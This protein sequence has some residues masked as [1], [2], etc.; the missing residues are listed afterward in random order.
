MEANLIDELFL[1]MEHIPE[2]IFNERCHQWSSFKNK[3]ADLNHTFSLGTIIQH[4]K[5]LSFD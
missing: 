4:K 5:L 1:R 3:I 2:Q